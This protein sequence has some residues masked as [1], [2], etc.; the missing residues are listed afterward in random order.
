[1]KE[2]EAFFD[3][4]VLLYSV[5][6]DTRK[7]DRSEELLKVGGAVSVQV[8]NE[9]AAVLR[10]KYRTPW[11]DIRTGLEIIRAQCRVVALTIDVH[12]RGVALAE[13]YGFSTYDAMIVA[14][15]LL[16]GCTVL[17]SEDMQHGLAIESLR[18]KNP[19]V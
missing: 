6:A 5:S 14:A 15:A 4:N 12:D 18:I 19:Y 1:M 13:R 16:A 2:G 11:I 17:Y 7:A 9:F 8:L 10:R 3:S